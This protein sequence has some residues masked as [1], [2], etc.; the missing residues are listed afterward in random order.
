MNKTA[1]NSNRLK[2][3]QHLQNEF[4]G[5]GVSRGEIALVLSE[6]GKY[7]NFRSARSNVN[8]F[9]RGVCVIS[10]PDYTIIKNYLKREFNWNLKLSHSELR[11]KYNCLKEYQRCAPANIN[12]RTSKKRYDILQ[13]YTDSIG[14][15]K[16]S[17]INLLIDN[18]IDANKEPLT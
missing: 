17:F 3:S 5:C 14:V 8:N 15:T 18:W 6:E 16:S 11:Q 10:K 4:R 9:L 13:K 2:L 12:I 7:K 1:I